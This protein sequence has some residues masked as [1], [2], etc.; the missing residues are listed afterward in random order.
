MGNNVEAGGAFVRLFTDK[1]PMIRGLKAARKDFDDWAAGIAGAGARLATVGAAGAGFSTAALKSFADAGGALDDVSQRT[2]A[3]VES[4]SRL[5]FAAQ[6][7]GTSLEAVEGATKKLQTKLADAVNGNKAAT[8]SF[9]S[10]GLSALR[11]AQLPLDRQMAEIGDAITAIDDPVQRANAAM[12][13]FGKSGT[14]LIPMFNGLSDAVERAEKL[15]LTWTTEEAENAAELGDR[16]DELTDVA[17]R[18][19]TVIGGALAPAFM[20]LSEPLLD[21]AVATKEFVAENPDLV[22]TVAAVTAGIGGAGVA[23]IGVAGALTV[24]AT[25]IEAFATLWLGVGAALASPIVL[26]AAITGF[27][28]VLTTQTSMGRNAVS[29]L[30]DQFPRV[31]NSADA[32]AVHV[33]NGF[34]ILADEAAAVGA[35]VN[36][37]WQGIVDAVSSGVFELAGEIAMA[38]FQ[39]VWQRG[40]GYI[41]DAWTIGTSAV[42]S[43]WTDTIAGVQEA[44]VDLSAW[45]ST[46]WADIKGFAFDAFDAIMSKWDKVSGSIADAVIDVSVSTG[47]MSGDAEEIKKTRRE[48]TANRIAG[49]EQRSESRAT[50]KAAE[51]AAIEAQRQASQNAID[52]EQAAAQKRIQDEQNAALN[53]TE[54][55]RKAAQQKLNDLT[56]EAAIIAE[57]RAAADE[58]KKKSDPTKKRDGKGRAPSS[59]EPGK[60]SGMP[61]ATT[62]GIIASLNRGGPAD[63]IVDPMVKQQKITNELLRKSAKPAVINDTNR[64]IKLD[65]NGKP[66]AQPNVI[67]NVNVPPALPVQPVPP[68]KPVV[69]PPSQR[70]ALR[71]AAMAREAR[72]RAAQAR[73]NAPSAVAI[74]QRKKRVSQPQSSPEIKPNV[75]VAPVVEVPK[76]KTEQRPL[77]DGKGEP[78]QPKVVIESVQVAVLPV[79]L[80]V[81]ENQPAVINATNSEIMLDS[82]GAAIPGD[83]PL[84]PEVEARK[85]KPEHAIEVTDPDAID[86]SGLFR[87]IEMT[88]PDL[89]DVQMPDVGV[90]SQPPAAARESAATNQRDTELLTSIRDVLTRLDLRVAATGSFT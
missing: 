71:Q 69:Q 88:L 6:M 55:A 4:L 25:A 48:D 37:A 46:L 83:R 30:R 60:G 22:T 68:L 36:T 77:T 42:T 2:G 73:R 82:T 15:G 72:N 11:L 18:T 64:E 76:T 52:A 78:G 66:V 54:M 7:G 19:V 87:G 8:K 80:P 51:L 5:Q 26:P 12:D 61:E 27:G 90:L 21:A 56:A 3:T 70:D 13:I 14:D 16:F 58:E 33:S 34:G 63:S 35:D 67:Q 86:L 24:V 85:W 81:S 75:V 62:S 40:V 39:A 20:E 41:T 32:M 79:E 57:E 50:D 49:R 43:I 29:S 23:L 1:S 10:L 53:A 59:G 28:Y 44:G 47:I 31:A 65:D 74:E 38:G 84:F 17:L 9:D 45:F 89:S